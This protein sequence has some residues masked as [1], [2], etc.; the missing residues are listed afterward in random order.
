MTRS[1]ATDDL[2]KEMDRVSWESMAV[3]LAGMRFVRA[4]VEAP[5]SGWTDGTGRGGYGGVGLGG[6]G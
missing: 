1:S 2:V 6:I 3:W 4:G 5:A